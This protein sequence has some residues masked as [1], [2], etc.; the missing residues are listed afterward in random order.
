[1]FINHNVD[2]VYL[3]SLC[4]YYIMHYIYQIM[5]LN[6]SKKKKSSV[7]SMHTIFTKDHKML[8]FDFSRENVS[9]K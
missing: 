3:K 6:F 9:K 1:M 2:S 5:C 7:N 8:R 4:T